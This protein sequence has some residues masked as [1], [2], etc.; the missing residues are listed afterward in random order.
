MTG[1]VELYT[2]GGLESTLFFFKLFIYL[3]ERERAQ[4]ERE[5]KTPCRAERPMQDSIPGP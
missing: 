2:I 5:K 3:F 4:K 1:Y